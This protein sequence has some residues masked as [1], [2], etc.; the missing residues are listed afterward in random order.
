MTCLL[1]SE[2]VALILL[3]VGQLDVYR[4]IIKLV[5][6]VEHHNKVT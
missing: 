6:L 1:S 5:P 2:Y 4:F 3:I